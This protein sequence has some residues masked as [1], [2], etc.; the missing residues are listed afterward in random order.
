[1]RT[2]AVGDRYVLEELRRGGFSLGGEQSGHVVVPAHATTGDG[3]LTALALMARMAATGQS[4]AE[5]AAVMQ[6]LPQELINVPVTDKTR[7][8]SSAEVAAAVAAAETELAGRGRG[9][10]LGRGRRGSRRGGD[11]TGR[12]RP[13]AAAPLGHRT[14]GAGDGRGAGHRDGPHGGRAAGSGGRAVVTAT[15]GRAGHIGP[16]HHWAQA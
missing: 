11:R 9:P 14:A 5:L 16:E 8:Q 4:L 10:G 2:T 6:V 7:V 3:L 13:G 12:P 1:L 15:A